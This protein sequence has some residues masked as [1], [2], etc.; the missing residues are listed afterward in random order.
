MVSYLFAVSN[1]IGKSNRA[2]SEWARSFTCTLVNFISLR[3]IDLILGT[4]NSYDCSHPSFVN[5]AFGWGKT[6]AFSSRI[7]SRLFSFSNW[8][9]NDFTE[10][11]SAKSRSLSS[12]VSQPVSVLSSKIYKD[13]HQNSR[14]T[15]FLNTH[16]PE[17]SPLSLCY[18]M[19]EWVC[20]GSC[21][22]S[23]SQPQSRVRYWRP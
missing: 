9:A 8:I 13:L 1:K 14:E 11:K 2:R 10:A 17:P 22:R 20:Q 19:R 3:S 12:A 7:S 23:V 21:G 16:Q 5:S 18:D 6:P 15:L 4:P